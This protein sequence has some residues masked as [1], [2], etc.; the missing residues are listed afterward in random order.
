MIS[1]TAEYALRAVICLASEPEEPHTTQAIAKR[2]QIPQ[3]YLSKVLQALGRAGIV[4]SQRGLHGGFTL[5][6]DPAEMTALD[7]VNAVDPIPRLTGCPLGLKAHSEKLCPLHQRLDDA[8]ASVE[9]ALGGATISEMIAT[10]SESGPLGGV[11]KG[12]AGTEAE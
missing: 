8:M 12:L 11:C 5:L 2:A 6:R 3:G 4:K 9:A 7:V 1:Q 10:G